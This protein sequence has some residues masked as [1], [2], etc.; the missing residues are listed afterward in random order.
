M[1]IQ[2]AS[3]PNF[4]ADCSS[5]LDNVYD[6]C[7]PFPHSLFSANLFLNQC[8]SG[9]FQVIGVFLY[10]CRTSKSFILNFEEKAEDVRR[11]CNVNY[12][13]QVCERTDRNRLLHVWKIC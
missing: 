5:L 4:L 13:L 3:C 9:I 12:L 8:Y 11:S 2:L 7:K 1:F 10:L 6:I